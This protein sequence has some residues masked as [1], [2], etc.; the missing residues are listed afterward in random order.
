MINWFNCELSKLL[1]VRN[2]QIIY[3]SFRYGN[4]VIERRLERAIFAL[5]HQPPYCF[6]GFPS[7]QVFHLCCIWIS[8]GNS[9]GSFLIWIDTF[10]DCVVTIYMISLSFSFFIPFSVCYFLLRFLLILPSKWLHVW[11]KNQSFSYIISYMKTF[12]IICLL[13]HIIISGQEA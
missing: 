6:Y 9:V 13:V 1:V 5:C 4:Y 2:V 11:K 3:H 7:S 8:I 10:K 12:S